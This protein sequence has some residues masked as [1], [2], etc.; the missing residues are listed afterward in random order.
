MGDLHSFDHRLAADWPPENWRD[1]TVLIA[2]SGGADSVALLRSLT[3][4]RAALPGEC[5]GR[6]IVAHFNHGFRGAESDADAQFVRDLAQTLGLKA[7]VGRRRG[8]TAQ[9]VQ[10]GPERSEDAARKLRYRFLADVAGQFGAR[11]LVT[12]HTA[13]DQ[14]ETVLM[15]V[16]RGTGLAG[17][18]GI[19]RVRRLSTATT[20]LRPM[21]AITR[22]QVLDYLQDLGQAFRHDSSNSSGDYVRNRIRREFLPLARELYGNVDEALRRLAILAS[23]ANSVLT[24]EAID[25]AEEALVT[26]HA[27]SLTMK[28]RPLEAAPRY[29][30]REALRWLWRQMGWPCQSMGQREWDLLATLI[31]EPQSAGAKL[32]LTLPG[33]IQAKKQGELLTLT[34]PVR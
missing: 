16:L 11:Y 32:S 9:N 13:D 33:N 19:P 31:R 22:A 27:D 4:L 21:L 5:P 3:R 17:L 25:L 29:L 26:R 2:V 24:A 6:L 23:E 18:S 30:A 7:V 34:R 12:A 1:V 20:L 8:R 15:R 10:R 14:S 28:C